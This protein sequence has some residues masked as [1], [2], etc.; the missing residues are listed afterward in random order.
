MLMKHPGVVPVEEVLPIFV[1]ALPLKS[2][3]EENEPVYTFL[4]GLLQ[5]QNAWLFNNI[6]QLLAIFI[7]VLSSPDELKPHTRQQMVEII[8]ALNSQFPALN[9]GATSLGPLLQ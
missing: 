3:F 9:I 6:S 4:F 7:Q 2:D 5:E 1:G 8:K